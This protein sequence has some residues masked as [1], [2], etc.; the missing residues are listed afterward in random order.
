MEKLYNA[1]EIE[2]K[3]YNFWE[4]KNLFKAKIEKDKKPFTI[5]IP[6]PNVTGSLHMGHAL[7]NTIQDIIIRFQRMKGNPVLWL[8]GTDHAGIATQNVVER[9]IAKEGLNRYQL[10]REKFLKRVWEWKEKYGNTIVF[11]LKKLGCSCDWSRLRFTMDE[12]YSKAVREVFVRW[13]KD[14]LIYKGKYVINWCVRCQTALSDI[15]VEYKEIKGNLWYINYPLFEEDGYLTVATTRPE[16]MLGD[17]AVAVHPEDIRYKKYI[18]KKVILPLTNRII[19]VIADEYVEKEFGTGVV[20]VTPAHDLSDFE[21]GLRHNLP[22]VVV[23][24]PQ[25]KMTEEAGVYK[26]LERFVC[27]EKILEDLKNS[28]YLQK[29]EEYVYSLSICSRCQQTIEPLLSEQWFVKMKPLAEPAIKAVKEGRVRFI[30]ERFTKIYL[31]WMENV[32]DW[33]ISR[34]IWWGHQI[35]VWYCENCKEVNV[36]VKQPDFCQKCGS[37]SLSQ[38]SDVLDTWF[39]SALWPFATLG[40]P[41]ETEDL[42]YFYPTSVLSTGRDIIYLWVA[43]MIITG[44]YFMKD[45]PFREVYIHPTVLN[46]EGKRM[47][48]SLG[49]G[50]DPLQLLEKY[51]A[52]ATRLGLIIQATKNQDLRFSEETLKACRNFMNKFWNA[53][54]FVLTFSHYEETEFKE[55][56]FS[57]FDKWI[58]KRYS[59]LL[60]NVTFYLENYEF[61][62]AAKEIYRFFWGEFCDWFIE[63][64][65]FNLN[66]ESEERKKQVCKIL[67]YILEGITKMLHPFAPFITEEIYQKIQEAKKIEEKESI[68]IAKWEK[69]NEKFLNYQEEENVEKIFSLIRGIRSLRHT[70]GIEP[71]RKLEIYLKIKKDISLVEENKN[72]IMF[73]ANLEKISFTD[74]DIK[75]SLSFRTDIGEIYLPLGEEEIEKEKNRLEKEISKLNEELLK[76]RKKLT[77]EKFLKGAPAEIVEKEKNKEKEILNT[78]KELNERI[79]KFNV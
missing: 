23:I 34:Q 15:E 50:V 24:S 5:V 20:K 62:E 16:T 44:L 61:N 11:Q 33:C 27:R 63:I 42:K 65:K 60:K 2:K 51:G 75:N 74:K 7:N 32:K 58:L 36:S 55:E 14:G 25:G 76:I 73:L 64:A 59:L 67:F 19:P 28:G 78:L 26:G 45:V 12:E 4:S 31:S 37:T 52:D 46:I 9:E 41:E 18:G 70:L 79:E 21:T 48:K 22:Y 40:W 53:A 3:W 69:E 72:Y 47:S 56:L 54:R 71:S 30:P 49:T 66:K 57:I 77:D 43:R 39:S 1:K 10:G 38:E 6:P 68:M 35:P 29:V 13:F 17:T 8:P